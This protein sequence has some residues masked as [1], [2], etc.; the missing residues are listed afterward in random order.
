[1]NF[2]NPF[3]PDVAKPRSKVEKP[4]ET[5]PPPRRP[6][7]VYDEDLDKIAVYLIGEQQRFRD[8]IIIPRAL[9]GGYIKTYEEKTIERVMES[10]AFKSIMS[11]VVGEQA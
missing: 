5:D 10:C 6:V 7:F 9:G 4:P 3:G 1:M 2:H 11:C 8:H